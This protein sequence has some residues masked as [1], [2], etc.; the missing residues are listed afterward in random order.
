MALALATILALWLCVACAGAI[1][2]PTHIASSMVIQRDVPFPL[3]GVDTPGATVTVALSSGGGA[4]LRT[5]AGGDGVFNVTLPAAPASTAP[6]SITLTSSSGGGALVLEDILFGDVFLESGQ[7]NA[8]LSVVSTVN[9]T[10]VAARAGAHG[11]TLRLFQVRKY[12]GA[13][14]ATSRRM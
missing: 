8:E 3:W 12:P 2:L 13:S 5:V 11:A 14:I 7:S 4:V 10:A 1:T 9:W 6:V